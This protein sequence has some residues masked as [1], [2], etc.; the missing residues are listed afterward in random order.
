MNWNRFPTGCCHSWLVPTLPPFLIFASCSSTPPLLPL[1]SSFSPSF[2][3]FL[4]PFSRN[5]GSKQKPQYPASERLIR[6]WGQKKYRGQ[7]F[8]WQLPTHKILSA[9]LTFG[10]LQ[11]RIL[12]WNILVWEPSSCV[13][14]GLQQ[15]NLISLHSLF[16]NPFNKMSYLKPVTHSWEATETKTL[17]TSK[18][19][20]LTSLLVM[21]SGNS[22][23]WIRFEH[24]D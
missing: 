4:S 5:R 3:P 22:E 1:Y 19:T 8:S 15:C 14:P 17:N 16:H 13:P 7:Y 20:K 24:N 18:E 21:S 9:P 2:S 12:C 6:M 23:T 10:E 11:R